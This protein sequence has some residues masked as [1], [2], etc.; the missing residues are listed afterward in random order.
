[1]EADLTTT[2]RSWQVLSTATS[3]V[4][5]RLDTAGAA[6]GRPVR[7]KTL[8]EVCTEDNRRGLADKTVRH[9]HRCNSV[10]R[11]RSFET[12][13]VAVSQGPCYFEDL[14]AVS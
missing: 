8:S 3:S 7:N 4:K 6:S 2:G 9:D 14:C 12:G 13:R 1:M 11:Q 5:I 10:S